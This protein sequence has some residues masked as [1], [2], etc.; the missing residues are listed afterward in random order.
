MVKYI[1]SRREGSQLLRYFLSWEILI[2]L[3]KL[4]LLKEKHHLHLAIYAV[5]QRL[6]SGLC[7]CS[8]LL[9]YGI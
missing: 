5:R 9:A 8:V 6:V 2:A 4:R 1:K 7:I 3:D